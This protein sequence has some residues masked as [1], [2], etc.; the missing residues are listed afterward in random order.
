MNWWIECISWLM[1]GMCQLNDGWIL[2]PAAAQPTSPQRTNPSQ[3]MLR[4]CHAQLSFDDTDEGMKRGR[5]IVASG[6]PSIALEEVRVFCQLKN[7]QQ[8]NQ[9]KFWRTHHRSYAGRAMYLLWCMWL[10]GPSRVLYRGDMFLSQHVVIVINVLCK[11]ILTTF[12][13]KQNIFILF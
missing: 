4:D 5:D 10:A 1:D 8:T 11:S 9:L 13:D 12:Q 7:R 6:K 3:P 2:S